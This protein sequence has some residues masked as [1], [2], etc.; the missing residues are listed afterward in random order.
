MT[1]RIPLWAGR[2]PIGEG[3]FEDSEAWISVYR[4]ANATGAS[5]LICPG[6]SYS[7]LALDGEGYPVAEW[8]SHRG[9][10][11]IV[12]ECRLPHGRKLVPLLDVQHAIRTFRVNAD[13]WGLDPTSWP[14]RLLGG[15]AFGVYGSD[16][17][18]RRGAG[19][20][21][22]GRAIQFSP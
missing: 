2:A 15:R 1:E 22:H 3:Q 13:Q 5:A 11:G 21:R 18:R 17:F 19:D 9:I 20:K 8:F 4:A 7:G 6:G 10:T 14:H 12:L 16:T